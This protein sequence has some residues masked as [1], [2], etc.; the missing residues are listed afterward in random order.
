MEKKNI[1]FYN[2]P[3]WPDVIE[4]KNI[5]QTYDNGKSWIIKD[6]NLLVEN[7]PHS[8]Q[9]I[10][11][12]GKSG[13]G[14]SSLLRYIAGLQRPTSGEL[15]LYGKTV[16]KNSVVGMVFQKYSSLP[17]L[18]VLDNVGLGLE[19]QDVPKKERAEKSMEMMKLV[20]LEG[21]EKKYAQ[22]PT[23]SGGQ[24][25]RVAIA[26]SLLANPKILLMDEPFGAL[27][28]YTRRK[29]Q[30]LLIKIW[31]TMEDMTVIFV[32]HDIPEAIYLS[33]EIFI[34]EANPGRIV[35]RVVVDLPKDRTKELKRTKKFID[36][37]YDIE[38][39]MSK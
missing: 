22:Y 27:D 14:K 18:S 31:N 9:F 16:T 39:K 33:E 25:Q 30:E 20:G 35:E 15:K 36:Q 5:N 21:Q 19:F 2:N 10:T 12:L 1:E 3:E 4:L 26:R 11:I 24:L 32:T 13:C 38:D 37:V 8:N 34:M 17:W 6:L 29:M 7:K 28:I 23:L